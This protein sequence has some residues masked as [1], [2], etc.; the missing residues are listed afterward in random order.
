ALVALREAGVERRPA[1]VPAEV[2]DRNAARDAEPARG[3]VQRRRVEAGPDLD[4]V[5]VADGVRRRYR[6]V[7]G[8]RGEDDGSGQDGQSAS[9]ERA[10]EH[11]RREWGRSRGEV[12]VERTPLQ[13]APAI[14]DPSHPPC[15]CPASSSSGVGAASTPSSTHS[16]AAPAGP[17]SSAPPA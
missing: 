11:R 5:P 10:T 6:A 4:G 3:G 1:A 14:F 12:R 17:T 15:P 7:W 8:R 16:A 13:R 9:E 2:L